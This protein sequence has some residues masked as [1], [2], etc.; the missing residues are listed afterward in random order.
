MIYSP[1]SPLPHFTTPY[2]PIL[3]GVGLLQRGEQ[4]HTQG[5]KIKRCQIKGVV[6]SKD[7]PNQLGT[8]ITLIARIAL[9]LSYS[10]LTTPFTQTTSHQE[11]FG[12]KLSQ[13]A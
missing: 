6:K 10:D 1:F 4:S 12:N 9:H 3:T 7:D 8:E 2:T 5:E 11:I 13:K